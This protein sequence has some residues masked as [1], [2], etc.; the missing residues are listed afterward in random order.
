MYVYNNPGE[1]QTL[2][3]PNLQGGGIIIKTIS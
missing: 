2:G 3:S 1:K